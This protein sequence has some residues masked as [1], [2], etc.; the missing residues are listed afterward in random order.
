VIDKLLGMIGEWLC[1]QSL[2]MVLAGLSN[3]TQ[4]GQDWLA[5]RA[6]VGCALRGWE[7]PSAPARSTPTRVVARTGLAVAAPARRGVWAQIVGHTATARLCKGD[8][9]DQDFPQR[10][11]CQGDIRVAR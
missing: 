6:M 2:S 11:E 1:E 9:R 7:P 3:I 5:W 4:R 8:Q 10:Q